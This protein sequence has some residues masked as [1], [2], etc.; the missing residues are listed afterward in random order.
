MSEGKKVKEADPF[1]GFAS[2]KGEFIPPVEDTDDVTTGDETILD[3][4]EIAKPTDEIDLEAKRLAAGDK[5][6][7]D[8]E[9][10]KLELAK[11]KVKEITED[12]DTTSDEEED[13]TEDTTK[14]SVI[15]AFAKELFN[16]GVLDFD[17]TDPEFEDSKEGLKK[18]NNKTIQ[19]Q[20]DKWINSKNPEYIKFMEFTDN[21]GDPREF[22]NIYYGNHSWTDFSI[23]SEDAQKLV[24][25]EALRLAGDSE[26]DISEMIEEWSENGTLAKRAKSSLPKLQKNET[27]Q[28]QEILVRAAAEKAQIE[29]SNKNYWES[30]KADLFKKEEVMGFKLTPKLKEKIWDGLTSIDIKTGKTAYQKAVEGN[31]DAIILFALQAVT[32]FDKTKLETQVKTKV[33]NEFHDLLENYSKTTKQK[34]S[35]GKTNEDYDTNPFAAF[36]NAK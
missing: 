35:S 19:N 29:E 1:E 13:E 17:D 8:L 26:E 21:G 34:V 31:K 2:L 3:T 36:K 24:V 16:D 5:A 7:A 30:F 11:K 25:M 22:L 15:R 28:K 23:E 14:T 33:S 32:G 27:T 9:K 12:E 6:L 10:K 4:P 20:I 18:L